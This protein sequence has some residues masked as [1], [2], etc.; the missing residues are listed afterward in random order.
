M[1]SD[2]DRI[3]TVSPPCARIAS[4]VVRA[5][6]ADSM[7]EWASATTADTATYVPVLLVSRETAFRAATDDRARFLLGF[8]DDRTPVFELLEASG[9]PLHDGVEALMTLYE[10]GL[11]GLAAPMTQDALASHR[12]QGCVTA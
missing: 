8:V 2:P 6:A 5:R 3:P 1:S 4:L 11:V 10:G 12:R 7:T 9:M